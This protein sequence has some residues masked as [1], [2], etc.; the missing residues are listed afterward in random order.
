MLFGREGAGAEYEC[1][2]VVQDLPSGLRAV[3]AVHSTLR[4]PAAGGIRRVAYPTEEAALSDALRLAW[5]MTLKN[6]FAELPAGGAKTV[7]LD[8]AGL[9]RPAAYRALG[10]AIDALGGQYLCG[11]DVGTGEAELAHVR[12]STRHVNAPGNDSNAATARGVVA[13]IRGALLARH[14]TDDLAGRS[15]LVQGLGGVG[16][17]VARRLLEAGGRVQGADPDPRAQEAAAARGV[18]L[19]A[20]ERALGTPCDVFV[21][22]ALGGILTARAALG[23]PADVVCG[24]ANNQLADLEAGQALHERGVLYVPDFVANAGAVIEGVYVARFG[25]SPEVRAAALAHVDA[26]QERV[27]HLLATARQQGAPPLE[28]ALALAQERART[29][30]RDASLLPAGLRAGPAAG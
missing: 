16:G 13:A 9:D 29:R 22:C 30:P 12:A 23:L 19:V 26:T 5:M 6:A 3:I 28:R 15:F 25:D 4:G 2:H 7:V 1:L 27:L 18:R 10:R 20:P 21:P 14:G 17:E 8:H 11:G 24:A